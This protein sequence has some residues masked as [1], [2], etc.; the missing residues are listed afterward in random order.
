MGLNGRW[1]CLSVVA[2]ERPWKKNISW[3]ILKFSLEGLGFQVSRQ[4]SSY[5]NVF[6]GL[7][8]IHILLFAWWMCFTNLESIQILKTFI[9]PRSVCKN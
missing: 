6:R 9:F 4:L 3:N 8:H 7:I 5:Y 2:G 1:K